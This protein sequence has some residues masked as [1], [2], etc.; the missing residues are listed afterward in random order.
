MG[1]QRNR[2]Q[3]KELENTP[4]KLDEMEANH[5]S[6]REFRAMIIRIISSMEKDIEIIKKD[7]SEIKN[8]NPEINN[9]LE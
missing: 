6:D 5:L 1:R 2:P 7:Q 9:T 4:E 3:M 8:A